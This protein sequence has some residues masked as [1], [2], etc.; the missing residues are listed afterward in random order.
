MKKITLLFIL[1][2]FSAFSFAQNRAMKN[3]SKSKDLYSASSKHHNLPN[4]LNAKNAFSE[5]FEGTFPP[6]NWTRNMPDGGTGWRVDTVGSTLNGWT[7]GST[8]SAPTGGG[9]QVACI[10]YSDGGAT[11]NDSWLITPQLTISAG[12]ALTFWVCNP[13]NYLDSMDVLLSTSTNAPA[14]FTTTL[15]RIAIPGGTT[16]TKYTISLGTYS[17]QQIYIAFREHIADNSADGGY[18]CLD[19]VNVITQPTIDAGVLKVTAPVLACSMSATEQVKVNVKNFGLNSLSNIPVHYKYNNGT[20]VDGT[21]A[22]PL[23]SGATVEYTFPTAIDASAFQIDSIVAWTSMTGDGD[24]TNDY[25]P[26]YY[27]ANV[28]PATAPYSM[29]FEDTE[30]LLGYTILDVN[31]DG[32]SWGVSNV[33]SLA[34]TGTNSLVYVYSTANA[35]DDWAISK[36]LNLS[37]G[38]HT[39][40]FWYR[41]KATSY[42]ESM[43]VKYGTAQTVAGMTNTLISLPS[44]T[45]MVY[46]QSSTTITI[47]SAG[48]Y[49]LGFHATS[50]ADQFALLIDDINIVVGAGG[51]ED[52]NKAVINIY[53]NPVKDVL[54]IE[55]TD[56]I[57]EVSMVNAIGQT[58]YHSGVNNINFTINTSGITEGVY[59]IK[60]KT[61][62]GYTT[63]KVL[64]N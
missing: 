51:I 26:T 22:G 45:N 39:I 20:T 32:Q 58:V 38:Q 30:S 33:D 41:A 46:Q 19:L 15:S 5:S 31:D 62:N 57:E 37:A 25:A 34:H 44:I 10:T 11:S 4:A 50:A 13:P 2:S 28:Q 54:F 40:S 6:T 43:E 27:F 42:P 1:L 7:G 36:C 35:A 9:N 61:A 18:V 63:H 16:W 49:Y 47:P 52:N 60:L 17:G 14:S 21:L 8:V 59:F 64:V 12:E 48:T 53:P 56:N 29:G 55:S 3:F 23:A 24:A